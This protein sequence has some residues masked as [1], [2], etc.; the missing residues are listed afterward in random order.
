MVPKISGEG[1]DRGK[2]EKR[3]LVWYTNAKG[4]G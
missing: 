3:G 1:L 4:V 2:I